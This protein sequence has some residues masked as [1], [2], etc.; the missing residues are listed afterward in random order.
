MNKKEQDKYV[1]RNRMKERQ[2]DGRTNRK[3][4]EW[5][6]AKKGSNERTGKKET[7]EVGT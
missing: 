2:T 1:N 4:K 5:K 7:K 6:E 3:I